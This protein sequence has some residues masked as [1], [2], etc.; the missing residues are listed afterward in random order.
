MFC[1]V[2]H[3]V[4]RFLGSWKRNENER[5]EENNTWEIKQWENRRDNSTFYALFFANCTIMPKM[6][7]VFRVKSFFIIFMI[8]Y[9]HFNVCLPIF[10]SLEKWD[11]LAKRIRE[12][13]I[14]PQQQNNKERIASKNDKAITLGEQDW[15][16]WLLCVV[17]YFW[18]WELIMICWVCVRAPKCMR[19]CARV[20]CIRC[21]ASTTD[22]RTNSKFINFPISFACS[23]SFSFTVSFFFKNE[24]RNSWN[25]WC[26]A[27]KTS[28][29][30]RYTESLNGGLQD[31]KYWVT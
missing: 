4:S 15:V 8:V 20:R 28:I 31:V 17:I 27:K 10:R 18:I 19:S 26:E 21:V 9:I 14:Q 22:T 3:S 12:K 29:R 24:I 2:T 6:N 23:F 1:A 25:N 16:E 5:K 7:F 30:D 11:S 13:K